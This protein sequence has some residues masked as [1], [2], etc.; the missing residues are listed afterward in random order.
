M[1]GLI[2][3]VVPIGKHTQ[4]RGLRLKDLVDGFGG[5][6][7]LRNEHSGQLVDEGLERGLQAVLPAPERADHMAPDTLL[8]FQVILVPVT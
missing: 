4:E 7:K 2:E 3:R 8:S 6:T 5:Q 1:R